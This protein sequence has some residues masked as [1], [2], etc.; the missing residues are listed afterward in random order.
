MLKSYGQGHSKL[1][2]CSLK[3]NWFNIM[4]VS[5]RVYLLTGYWIFFGI[6]VLYEMTRLSWGLES[7]SLE[8]LYWVDTWK[9][10]E[11]CTVLEENSVKRKQCK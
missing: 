9:K 4:N 5:I 10:T 6:R 8:C 2:L 7:T 11:K 1:Y 3:N